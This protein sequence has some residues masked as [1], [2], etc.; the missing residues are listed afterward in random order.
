M[1]WTRV[2]T[3]VYRE[4]GHEAQNSKAL[5]RFPVTIVVA[6]MRGFDLPCEAMPGLQTVGRVSRYV[7]YVC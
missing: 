5:Y 3:S 7:E 1:S 2:F 6:V 4:S